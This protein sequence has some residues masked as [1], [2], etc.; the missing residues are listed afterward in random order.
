[1]VDSNIIVYAAQREHS[2]RRQFIAE[3]APFVSVISYIE[4]LGYHRLTDLERRHFEDFFAATVALPISDAVVAQAVRLRQARRMPLGD[5][6]IAS[7]ALIQGL[8]LVTRNTADF[9]WIGTLRLPNP[10]ATTK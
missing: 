5:A 8:T 6:L 10:F 3:H 9:E 2:A 7:T 1:L 4:V